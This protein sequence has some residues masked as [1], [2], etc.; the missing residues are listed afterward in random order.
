MPR[1]IVGGTAE[2]KSGTAAGW[3]HPEAHE[4][5]VV[6]NAQ[7]FGR[8]EAATLSRQREWIPRPA[9]GKMH[10]V[11]HRHRCPYI[12]RLENQVEV[13][14]SMCAGGLARF[15]YSKSEPQKQ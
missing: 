9:R 11:P 6:D 4:R 5:I 7:P 2:L 8:V 3:G 13:L 10:I 12:R 14:S 15:M 1:L